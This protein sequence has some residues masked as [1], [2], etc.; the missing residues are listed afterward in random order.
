MSTLNADVA[1][2][3]C[4]NMNL[5]TMIDFGLQPPTNRFVPAEMGKQHEETHPLALGYCEDCGTAQLTARMPVDVVRPRYS[6]LS[7]NEPEGHLDDVAEQLAA[8]P[9]MGPE[10]RILGLTYKDQSTLNRLAKLDLSQSAC[11]SEQ[12]FGFSSGFFGLETIQQLLRDS[13]TITRLREK[14]GVANMLLM[15]HIIEHTDNAAELLRNLKG[16][17]APEGYI[18][19]ELPDSEQIF[20]NGNHAFIW[21]E[22]ISYFT[23]QSLIKLATAAGAHLA[24]FQRYRYPY[25]DSLLVAFR[26]STAVTD[27]IAND[28]HMQIK[29]KLTKFGNDFDLAKRQWREQLLR[30]QAQGEKVAV[31][32]AGHLAVKFINFLGLSDLI[33]CVIDDNPNKAGMKMPGSLLSIVPTA[34]LEKRRI[35]VCISTLSPESEIKV[36]Q[37]LSSYFD[38]GGTWL[39][40]FTVTNISHE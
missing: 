4:S 16:L 5:K 28:D 24:W 1:C 15:R 17:V 9:T 38:N 11:I 25:E 34:E 32:G 39:S 3:L 14:Y 33:D 31:F 35:R 29:D 23:E 40:A 7:Y 36:R 20:R 2:T 6:W 21:E 26:F 22:H 12:D 13:A 30:Y 8:L 10:S 18:V 19:L 27:L 37:K